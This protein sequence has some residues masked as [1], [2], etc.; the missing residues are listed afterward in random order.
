M[1]PDLVNAGFEIFGA[2]CIFNHCRVLMQD[3]QVKGVSMDS[4]VFFNVWGL[5]N[6]FF[7][8]SLDQWWSAFGGLLMVAANTFWVFLL[9]KYRDR[10]KSRW[11]TNLSKRLA[12]RYTHL[13]KRLALIGANRER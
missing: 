3:R 5:W 8:P 12:L 13:S 10:S 7:Y 9:Y 6:L 4:V 1:Q 11:Y 2:I